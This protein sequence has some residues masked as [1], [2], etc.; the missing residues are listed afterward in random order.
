MTHGHKINNQG[1][2]ALLYSVNQWSDP[3]REKKRILGYIRNRS[4]GLRDE[5]GNPCSVEVFLT[6]TS[7]A[8]R[9]K[10]RFLPEGRTLKIE[11]LKYA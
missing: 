10:N 9:A 1:W 7:A 3:H 4:H 2:A 6:T 8:G 11:E 5:S